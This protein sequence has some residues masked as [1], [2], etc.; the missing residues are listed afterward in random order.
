MI[1]TWCNKAE[2]LMRLRHN[3]AALDALNEATEMD[4]SYVR[5]EG[6]LKARGL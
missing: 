1:Y 5:A 6:T 4:K 3:R 2:A